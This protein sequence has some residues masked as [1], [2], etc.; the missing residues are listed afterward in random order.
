[1]AEI[2]NASLLTKQC[3]GFFGEIADMVMTVEPKYIALKLQK[4]DLKS[5]V[6]LVSC[7]VF[8]RYISKVDVFEGTGDPYGENFGQTRKVIET[9]TTVIP[10]C[11]VILKSNPSANQINPVSHVSEDITEQN[12]LPEIL[13]RHI[14]LAKM[15]SRLTSHA[16][17]SSLQ[18]QT[19]VRNAKKVSDL[20]NSSLTNNVVDTFLNQVL[21]NTDTLFRNGGSTFPREITDIELMR[22]ISESVEK[23]VKRRLQPL[24]VT[25]R[26]NLWL[27]SQ[28]ITDTNPWNRLDSS[29]L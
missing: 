7:K 17:S 24:L 3:R 21:Y 20:I 27:T 8:F 28:L 18:D 11:F 23:A 2:L 22:L 26:Q 9:K 12:T 25:A 4:D 15:K 29:N 6:N 19:Y 5:P 14:D 1:M 13:Y 16:A 10:D